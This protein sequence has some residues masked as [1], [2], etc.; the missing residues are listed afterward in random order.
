MDSA[1]EPDGLKPQKQE[2]DW[3]DVAS[4]LRGD[5]QAQRTSVYQYDEVPSEEPFRCSWHIER[6]A[7]GIAIEGH[8]VGDLLLTCD[9]CQQTFL[10][11]IALG[12]DE[13]YVLSG[14][15]N[16]AAGREKEL[17]SD[18]FYEVIDS[19]GHIDLKDLGYQ[20]L[21]MES[22]HYPECQNPPCPS[23]GDA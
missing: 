6:R 14:Y 4:V 19:N 3:L 13:L 9:A 8:L 12:I 17:Q 21:V 11:P 10:Q 5:A 18:D 7:G 20:Y 15:D 2:Q 23:A 16:Q 22:S 1:S